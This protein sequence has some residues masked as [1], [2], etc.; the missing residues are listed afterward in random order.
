MVES[1][2]R[3]NRFIALSMTLA[4][5]FSFMAPLAQPATAQTRDYC[6]VDLRL[7]GGVW[8]VLQAGISAGAN[9]DCLDV[10]PIHQEACYLDIGL[11]DRVQM[12]TKNV[13]VDGVWVTGPLLTN[14]AKIW[15]QEG[16]VLNIA[17][18]YNTFPAVFENGYNGG[19]VD[20]VVFVTGLEEDYYFYANEDPYPYPYP[21][22]SHA[23][24]AA[25]WSRGGGKVHTVD[26]N[27]PVPEEVQWCSPGYWKNNLANWPVPSTTTFESV[28]GYE[29]VGKKAP[30]T[31]ATLLYVLENPKMYGGELTEL[32]ADYLSGEHPDIYFTG[33]R[34]NQA[35]DGTWYHVCPLP[36]N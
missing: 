18:P 15:W 36:G 5:V 9:V 22:G 23:S 30:P 1:K 17:G 10:V 24:G 7:G 8:P 35:S 25:V 31:G 28:F 3:R 27:C 12:Q 32:V 29:P 26:T 13:L 20:I 14:N 21:K 2:T 33:D 16:T 11:N 34:Y 4:L 6:Y 19:S